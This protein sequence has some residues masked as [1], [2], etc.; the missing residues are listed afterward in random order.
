MAGFH[1]LVSSP[2][3]GLVTPALAPIRPLSSK[4]DFFCYPH[5]KLFSM[6]KLAA[7]LVFWW[8]HKNNK[9]AFTN[10]LFY[11]KSFIEKTKLILSHKWNKESKYYIFNF[12]Y[13]FD[14][15]MREGILGHRPKSSLGDKILAIREGDYKN[16]FREGEGRHLIGNGKE[17]GT[18]FSFSRFFHNNI[19][20]N[21]FLDFLYFFSKI[22]KS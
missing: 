15:G 3:K 6:V 19:K 21:Y 13:Y 12:E 9:I 10:I 4:E 18:K 7:F 1:P 5:Q 22:F 17:T 2:D 11:V 8:Q 14:K 16:C 20:E